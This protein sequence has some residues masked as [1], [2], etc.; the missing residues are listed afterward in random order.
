MGVDVSVVVPA[1]N[2]KDSIRELVE[3]LAGVLGGTG[4]RYEIVVVDDGSTDG[5]FE[6]L[7]AVRKTVPELRVVRLRTNF[8]QTAAMAAGFDHA[9]GE[10]IV[11]I[12]ADLQ[13]D[14]VDIPALL[15]KF[16]E[17][18]DVVS[19][20]RRKRR[21]P[22]L[23][24]RLPS[25]CANWVISRITGVRLHDYGCTL[26]VY[27]QEVIRN[28]DLYGEMHRFIPALAKWVGAS[29]VEMPVGHH[30]RKYG[31]SKYGIGRT[32]RVILDLITVRFLLSYMTRPIHM[33]GLLGL[34]SGF[35]GFVMAVVLVVQRQ[36]FNKMA[37]ANRPMLLLA[38]LLILLGVQFISMGLLSEML[39]R[40]YHESQ[41]KPIYV[42]R[43]LLQEEEE[44]KA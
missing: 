21:D 44:P 12:D 34:G 22:F 11:T 27:R 7:Q 19:G 13:N 26:K 18:Y 23:S 29:V 42:V 38:V 4:R 39:V 32:T 16:D 28:I 9:R 37:L 36:F 5:T 3:R 30:A 17:G 43:E 2:E 1:F 25:M 35:I 31:R 24:R 8:G 15:E 6:I 41:G 10:A 40:T 20:W 33:F 14:P